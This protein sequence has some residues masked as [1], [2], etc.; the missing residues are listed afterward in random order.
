MP[1]GGRRLIDDVKYVPNLAY[2]LLS[3]GQL[4][5]NGYRLVFEKKEML[6]T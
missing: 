3:V 6:Y 1:N 4:V 5:D 2:N